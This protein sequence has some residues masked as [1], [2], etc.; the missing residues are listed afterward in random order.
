MAASLKSSAN[1]KMK[2][3]NEN[4]NENNLKSR[5]GVGKLSDHLFA[6]RLSLVVRCMVEK[7]SILCCFSVGQSFSELVGG[8]MSRGVRMWST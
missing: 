2:M 7:I 5:K 1:G 6:K 4:E 3:N 8:D